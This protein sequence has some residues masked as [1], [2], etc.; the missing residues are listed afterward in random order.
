MEQFNGLD[1]LDSIEKNLRDVTGPLNEIERRKVVKVEIR[2]LQQKDELG[3]SSIT[4]RD[5]KVYA[6]IRVYASWASKNDNP[7]VTLKMLIAVLKPAL[8]KTPE[9][10]GQSEDQR[11]NSVASIFYRLPKLPLDDSRAPGYGVA[12]RRDGN[13]V[14]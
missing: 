2:L 5:A 4:R 11:Y 13:A 10:A 1:F 9:F 7:W 6:F 14:N 12:E 3:T 8:D